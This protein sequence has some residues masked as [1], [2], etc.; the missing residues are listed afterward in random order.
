MGLD[1][2]AML[3]LKKLRIEAGDVPKATDLYQAVTTMKE[4][5]LSPAQWAATT[6][7]DK[8]V[9]MY[10]RAVERYHQDMAKANAPKPKQAGPRLR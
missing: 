3:R 8:K 6:R 9:M 7:L 5:N 1:R 2:P 4:F 10:H